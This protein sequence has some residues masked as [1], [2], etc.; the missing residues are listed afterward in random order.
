[1]K[2]YKIFLL[3]LFISSCKKPDIRY[4][5]LT[6]VQHKFVPEWK[7]DTLVAQITPADSVPIVYDTLIMDMRQD[8]SF[9]VHKGE[10]YYAWVSSNEHAE[11][12]VERNVRSNN[13]T[14]S[15]YYSLKI[16]RALFNDSLAEAG[17]STNYFV[18]NAL[19]YL[20]GKKRN[21]TTI[22]IYSP[23]AIL[24]PGSNNGLEYFHSVEVK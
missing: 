23:S 14:I 12:P 8:T 19:E 21:W 20:E 13:D 17:S 2:L 10:R 3:F 22:F 7:I 18:P 9:I 6:G 16:G 11:F 24:P 5:P 15:I 4:Y 1:M